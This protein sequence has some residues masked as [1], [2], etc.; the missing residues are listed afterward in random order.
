MARDSQKLRVYALESQFLDWNRQTCRL[1]D[2]RAAV[3]WACEKYGITPPRVTQHAG[4]AYSFSQGAP[5]NIISF[6]K[7]QINPAVALH[8]AAHFICGQ[9]FGEWPTAPRDIQDH[10]PE[11]LGCY[12]WLLE[13]YR[14]LP[15]SALHSAAK[16]KKLR[17]VPTWTMSPKRLQRNRSATS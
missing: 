6:R 1:K 10:G 12:F 7:D 9:I 17:W 2:A 14:V 5:A 15:R 16:A 11:F 13:G 3:H 8:E 4:N